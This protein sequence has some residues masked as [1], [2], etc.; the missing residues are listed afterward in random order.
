MANTASKMKQ[1]RFYTALDPY[2]YTVDNRPLQDINDNI[3]TL[4]NEIDLIVGGSDRAAHAA[5]SIA[6]SSIGENVF[7]ADLEFPGGLLLTVKHGY[8]VMSSSIDINNPNFKL[9][10]MALHDR[11][12]RFLDIQASTTP[13]RRVKYLIQGRMDEPNEN[14]RIPASTSLAKVATL[15]IKK[16]AE[17][18]DTAGEPTLTPDANHLAIASF[19][20]GYGQTTLAQSDIKALSWISSTNLRSIA[21]L[22]PIS[23]ADSRIVKVQYPVTVAKGV[24]KISL[25]GSSIDLSYGK[26]SI[27][28]YITGV[29]QTSFTANTSDNSITLG[30]AMVQNGEVNI[31]QRKIVSK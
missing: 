1:V 28:V 4:C 3:T 29:Y 16:S 7:V 22:G 26:D 23:L 12:T 5:A 6:A 24:S 21:K 11:P 13:G 15:T 14:S 10:T 8:M 20:L 19:T 18:V 31:V 27:D 2:Y 25:N 9:P 30:G 17:Y